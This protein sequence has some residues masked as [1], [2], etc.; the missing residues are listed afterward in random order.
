MRYY[1]GIGS[2]K[3]P[4]EFQYSLECIGKGLASR[5]ILRSGAADGADTAFEHGCKQTV[6][7]SEIYLPWKGFNADSEQ[8]KGLWSSPL[9]L[10]SFP[11]KIQRAAESLAANFHPHWRQLTIGGKKL[12]IR[13]VFQVLGQ[14]LK[15][16]SEF[17]VCWTPDGQ[18]SGGT[19]QAIRIARYYGITV[20]N[21][22]N[23]LEKEM[24]SEWWI[25]EF[26]LNTI[27]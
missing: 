27:I 3:T 21:V 22:N 15:T 9:F 1:T 17:V 6:G 23:T 5:F 10:D 2:R 18:D 26:G 11:E 4:P 25:N 20:Y 19:S 13:N 8:R 12:H 16:P 14:D 24:F 7:F